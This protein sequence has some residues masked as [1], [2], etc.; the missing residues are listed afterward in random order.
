M[1]KELP[2]NPKP[3]RAATADELRTMLRIKYP[4]DQS[5]L[6]FEVRNGAGF[7]AT[8]S[9]DALVVGLWPSRGCEIEGFEIKVSRADWLRELK[10]F[11][12]ADSFYCYCN[13]FWL[14]VSNPDIV[15]DGELPASWGLMAPRGNG[16]GVIKQAPALAPKPLSNSFVAAMLKRACGMG[17]ESPEVIA[18]I[19]RARKEEEAR[20]SAN[21]SYARTHSQGELERLKKSVDEFEKAS[22]LTITEYNGERLGRDVK[23]AQALSSHHMRKFEW[24]R[25]SAKEL[26][27]WLDEKIAEDAPTQKP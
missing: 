18:A 13:K 5:A 16:L 11:S 2:I 4:A 17:M 25:Q 1:Q 14:L 21:L 22:G 12:K 15:A 24:M 7:E 27:E 3:K 23:L 10:D 9:L 8:R 26:L 19:Q 6:L 20:H